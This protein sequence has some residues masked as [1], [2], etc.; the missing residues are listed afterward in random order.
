M[1]CMRNA[2]PVLCPLSALA[3][4]FFFRWGRDGAE[5]FPSLRQP[6][7]YYDLAALPGSIKVPARPL[8]DHTQ[9]DWLD[10]MYRSVGITK[11]IAHLPRRQSVRHAELIGVPETQN[12]RAGRWSTD[13]MTGAYLSQLPRQFMRSSAGWPQEG[14]AYSLPRAQELPDEAL[15]SR[16]WPEV[17]LWM[18]RMESFHPDR[19]DNEVV[20]LDLAGTG[21]LRLLR[22]LRVILLQ[23]SV[24]LR[25]Q[26]PLHPL[27]K[28]SLFNCPEYLRFA[29]R[30]E[31][32]AANAV[33][34]AE[35]TMRQY[36]P[37]Q[38]AVAKLR[39]DATMSV[40]QGVQMQ[41]GEVLERL[42]Q[43]ERSAAAFAPIWI[44]QSGTGIW[45]GPAGLA[46]QPYPHY[47]PCPLPLPPHDA[48]AALPRPAR[49]ALSPTAAT[50]AAPAPAPPP[51]ST[52]VSA[53]AS[54]PASIPTPTPT[55]A[56]ASTPPPPASAPPPPWPLLPPPPPPP[57][58][59]APPAAAAAAAAEGPFILDPQA[60]ARPYKMLRGSDSVFQ[61]WTEWTFG[62]MCG[63]SIEALNRC[64]GARWRVGSEAM[65]YSRRNKVIAEI[66]RRVG[67]GTARDERQAVDQLEQLRGSR[68]LDWLCKHIDKL[69]DT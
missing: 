3:F 40:L 11:R 19:D 13:A 9:R 2:D 63:P 37:V 41:I 27:W 56:P 10:K 1:G 50:T 46:H 7:D 68:S 30:A 51:A 17:D 25:K 4:Y 22:A 38:E 55:P 12:R 5:E 61:L 59:A 36:W 64:W 44:Q 28:D 16:I 53:P 35:L 66:R 65:F 18:K 57:A 33:T 26:F 34:P 48:P 42:G 31:R 47:P 49:P 8:S 54:P 29:K 58:P 15:C 24:I 32:S 45:M 23:D 14:K 69:I 60:P 6:E 39:Y 43:M 21:F 62:L 52:P 67:N 20:Q